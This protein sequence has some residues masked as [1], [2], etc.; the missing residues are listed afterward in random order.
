[1]QN[2]NKNHVDITI[3]ARGSRRKLA[4]STVFAPELVEGKITI[5]L[6]EINRAAGDTSTLSANDVEIETSA[7]RA[8]EQA[9]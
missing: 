1:M 9:A 6:E 2:N 5:M 3:S 7:D 8:T 4:T